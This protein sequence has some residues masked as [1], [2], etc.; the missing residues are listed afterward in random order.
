MAKLREGGYVVGKRKR[1]GEPNA[2]IPCENV[3]FGE[4]CERHKMMAKGVKLYFQTSPF[5]ILAL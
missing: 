1:R 5:Y 4:I 3:R 2:L